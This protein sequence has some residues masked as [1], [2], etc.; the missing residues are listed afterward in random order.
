MNTTN[1]A[2][3]ENFFRR[4]ST[5]DVTSENRLLFE[6]HLMSVKVLLDEND[7]TILQNVSEN[8]SREE[9]VK[10]FVALRDQHA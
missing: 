7:A 10:L 8:T 5:M 1:R 3:L 6:E 2:L 9:F 4:W